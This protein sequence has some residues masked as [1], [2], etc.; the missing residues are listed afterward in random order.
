MYDVANKVEA[1]R[2]G[3]RLPLGGPA[4]TTA[5]AALSSVELSDFHRWVGVRGGLGVCG[6]GGGAV[7]G[8]GCGGCVCVGGGGC[9]PLGGF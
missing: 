7:W 1:A 8:G 2:W 9:L 3:G 6:G 5:K 4:S